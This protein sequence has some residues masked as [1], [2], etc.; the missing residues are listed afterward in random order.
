VDTSEGLVVIVGCSHPGILPMLEKIRSETG[1]PLYLV[2]GGF[3]LL[4]RSE[5]EAR[6]LASAMKAMGA[7]HVS[8][9]HCSGE[10]AVHAFRD[11]FGNR[12]VSAGVGAVVE[13]PLAGSDRNSVQ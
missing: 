5:G 8:P 11:I 1:R 9:A 2:I 3:H 7:A 10:T 13:C 6:Q 4:G 12:Y